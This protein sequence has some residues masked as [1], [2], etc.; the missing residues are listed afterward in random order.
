MIELNHVKSGNAQ[1][2]VHKFIIDHETEVLYLRE[3]SLQTLYF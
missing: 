3:S 1:H 2:E